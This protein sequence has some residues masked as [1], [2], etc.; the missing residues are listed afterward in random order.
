MSLEKRKR[1]LGLGSFGY[2]ITSIDSGGAA[3]NS[4]V[5][6]QAYL[7]GDDLDMLS[8]SSDPLLYECPGIGL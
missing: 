4:S 7:R 5:A 2:F 6:V 3:G 1:A 8:G